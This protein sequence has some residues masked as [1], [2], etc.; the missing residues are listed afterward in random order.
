M[1]FQFSY[2]KLIGPLLYIILLSQF[3]SLT[4]DTLHEAANRGSY[5]TIKIVTMDQGD[6]IYVWFGH[7]AII[8]EDALTGKSTLYDYGV[9][10]FRQDNFYRNFAMG[11]LIYGV[12][13]T[14]PEYRFYEAEETQRNTRILTLDL[15][16]EAK[17]ELYKF[18]QWNIQPENSS[19]LYH[20]Y[21]DN[22]ATR[23][24]DIID[25]AVDG[26]LKLWSQNI[27]S[28]FTYREHIRRYT[29]NHPI[30]DWLL[31]FLQSGVIDSSITLW[32]EMFLPDR[33]ET[34][35]LH[36]SYIDSQGVL[37]P[38]VKQQE[39]LY[40][41]PSR[42]QIPSD[43]SPHWYKALPISLLL[44]IV[45]WYVFLKFPEFQKNNSSNKENKWF[46]ILYYTISTL[47]S[48]LLGILGSLLFFMSFFTD[49]TVTYHNENLFLAN[50]ILLIIF[51]ISLVLIFKQTSAKTKI[52]CY[53]WIGVGSISFIYLF[54]K[55]LTQYLTQS[56]QLTLSLLVP[57][58][59]TFTIQGI[60]R[61]KKM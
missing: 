34:A 56:N 1:R 27:I 40:S 45:L 37:K 17:L 2:K 16:D 46:I 59:V 4:A 14:K 60:L 6:P 36:F 49:H 57:V 29:G 48:F 31:N 5:L 41:Y 61:L 26:Q 50:P 33:F 13:A 35:L 54:I 3:W 44:S 58:I 42:K 30:V 51:C 55:L 39:I 7:S 15:E 28:P 52:F 25:S 47:F 24:R 32:D 22:C 21:Y 43:W 8:V 53:S 23:I 20:H 12:Y 19:Y 11:R 38:L 10:D 18:L 9:F